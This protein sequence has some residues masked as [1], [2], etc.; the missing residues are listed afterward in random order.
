V[1]DVIGVRGARPRRR[2][3]ARSAGPNRGLQRRAASPSA[4]RRARPIRSRHRPV[5]ECPR[6]LDVALGPGPEGEDLRAEL[7]GDWIRESATP[8][9]QPLD[10]SS[11]A[12]RPAAPLFGRR[13]RRRR[14]GFERESV[15]LGLVCRR[16]RRERGKPRRGARPGWRRRSGRKAATAMGPDGQHQDREGDG[17][18]ARRR[19]TDHWFVAC[20]GRA[21]P[22]RKPRMP[23]DHRSAGRSNARSLR[24]GVSENSMRVLLRRVSIRN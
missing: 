23:R 15:P 3:S 13:P 9:R 1:L 7:G 21:L 8:S 4:V 17:E 10:R 5:L 2:R 14:S 24:S 11:K 20:P 22:S 6:R 12:L 16:W 19:R 18:C